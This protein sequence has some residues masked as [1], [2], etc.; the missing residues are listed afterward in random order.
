MLDVLFEGFFCSLDVLKE[1]LGYVNCN[2]CKNKKE[3]KIQ[4]YFLQI[5]VIKMLKCWIRVRIR[6]H[7]TSFQA[8]ALKFCTEFLKNKICYNVAILLITR[9]V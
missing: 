4:L 9:L 6:F 3:K 1:A 5:L 7:N 2:F 8:H